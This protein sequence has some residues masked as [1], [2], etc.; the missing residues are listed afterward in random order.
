MQ[1]KKKIRES[2]RGTGALLRKSL[3]ALGALALVS[4]QGG[5]LFEETNADPHPPVIRNFQYAPDS[6]L[7]GAT[8]RGSFTYV[9]SGGDIEVINMRDLS[10]NNATDP[11]PFV[12]GVSDAVCPEGETCPTPPSVFFFP[13]TT[14]TVQWEMVLESNQAGKH[15]IKVWLE[16][17]KDTW[18]E[19]VFFDVFIS[20]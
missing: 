9:D 10:G 20:F 19:P 5:I 1:L 17:S 7:T 12:P 18:S 8:I 13:G 11:I 3:L 16:D 2:A 14:G 6:I 15:T 4:C